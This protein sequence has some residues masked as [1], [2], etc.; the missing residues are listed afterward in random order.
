M[1]GH[2]VYLLRHGATEWSRNG[3]HTGITDIPLLADGRGEAVSVGHFLGGRPFA[4]VLTS[5]RQ[6]A[7]ETCELAGYQAEAEV[8]D[9]LAE[10]DYGE[11][12]G[13]TTVEIHRRHPGWTIWDGPIPGGETIAQVS[14]RADRV[15]ER[16]RAADGD[17]ALFAHGHLLR[18]VAA[19]W[20]ELD[21]GE[22]RR[23]PLS[24]GTINILGWE[25]E[26]STLRLWNQPAGT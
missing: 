6:R 1:T 5:P 21:P 10:W 25:H 24:T 2:E 3:R 23:F 15:I 7:R 20:C 12:E 16:A 11:L 14:E 22:G 9:D 8:T 19:R 26:I 4:L 18:V 17:V 13:L